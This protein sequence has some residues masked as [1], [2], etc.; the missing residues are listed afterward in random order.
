VQAA[1]RL[2]LALLIV[3]GAGAAHSPADAAGASSPVD[4]L[5]AACP[6][7]SQ[8]AAVNADLQLRFES[9][10]T[11][12]TLACTS[13]GGSVT[14]TPLQHRV[15][16]TIRAMKVLAFTRPLPWT[17]KSLYSWLVSAIDG[18]RFRGD[19]DFSYCCDP[20]R[21]INVRVAPNS[22]FLLTDRWIEPALGGGLYDT[23]ALFVH[24]ARH[25]DGLPHTCDNFDET[26]SELG[27]WG[28]QYYLGIWTAL[29]SGSFLDAPGADPT[30]YRVSELFHAEGLFTR[31]CTLPAADLA[32]AARDL[33][34]PVAPGATLS[35]RV[36]VVNAGPD[37]APR[38]FVQAETP[39]G[40]SFLSA[41]TSAGS[42]IG[43]PVGGSGPLGCALG[44]LASGS[45]RS[46]ELNVN[47]SAA[48]GTTIAAAG[49][50]TMHVIGTA[51][52]PVPNNNSVSPTTN[53]EEGAPP[54]PP[55][56]TVCVVPRVVGLSLRRARIRIS[57]ANC[58]TGRV[59][60]AFSRK[61][62]NRVLAQRPRTGTRL[63]ENAPVRLR[64]SKGRRPQRYSIALAACGWPAG[65]LAVH[66]MLE[67]VLRKGDERRAVEAACS[68]VGAPKLAGFERRS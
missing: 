17:S 13:A 38:V 3:M 23:A 28:V 65:W 21:F 2:A 43:P 54:P 60:R 15:Y 48:A 6:S 59:T 12:G 35:Y 27:A 14:L 46:L 61:P 44:P 20:D 55:P 32:I 53:V 63:K 52:D 33:P 62:K 8:V 64:V 51:R 31:F 26:I 56:P 58:T 49:A 40:T 7:P 29:Y 24:E 36:Q 18:I 45:S 19:I 16:Q 67:D 68:R 42:C 50:W 66:A 47:V 57:K 1:L 4:T 41:S 37:T 5:L 39:P 30:A 25:S 10:P 11:I 9:D 34:D 22:Y